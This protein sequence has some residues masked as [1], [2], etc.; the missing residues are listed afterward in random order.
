MNGMLLR[1]N[2]EKGNYKIPRTESAHINV[3]WERWRIRNWSEPVPLHPPPFTAQ[4]TGV[5]MNNEYRV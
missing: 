5:S 3:L 4:K 2:I 1:G